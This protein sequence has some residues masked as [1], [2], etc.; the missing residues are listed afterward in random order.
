MKTINSERDSHRRRADGRAGRHRQ[1]GAGLQH[2]V[3][4]G[5]LADRPPGQHRRRRR[6]ALCAIVQQSGHAATVSKELACQIFEQILEPL[7]RAGQTA[8]RQTPRKAAARPRARQLTDTTA[9]S[10]ASP[11]P[12]L[13]TPATTP[14]STDLLGGGW[15]PVSAPRSPDCVGATLAGAALLLTGC[16]FDGAYDLPLPGLTGRR[17]QLLRGHRRV[18]RHPQRRAPL[19]GHGRRRHRRRGDRGRARRLARQDH[20]A[21]ARRTSSSPTT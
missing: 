8:T 9:N 13:R 10:A 1:P 20:D 19:A 2:P 12:H 16:E 11:C 18:R 7:L 6:P 21:G 5:R 4:L 14:P 3:R 15:S 17:G